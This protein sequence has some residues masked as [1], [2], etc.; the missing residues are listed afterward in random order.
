MA[1]LRLASLEDGLAPLDPLAGGC[2]SQIDL[3]GMEAAS[4]GVRYDP[5]GRVSC[6]KLNRGLK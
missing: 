3:L 2:G 6:D 5:S 1:V 4:G